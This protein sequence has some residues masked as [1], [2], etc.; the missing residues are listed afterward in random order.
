MTSQNKKLK[1]SPPA[2]PPILTEKAGG[3]GGM[4]HEAA[5]ASAEFLVFSSQLQG[6]KKLSLHKALE[7]IGAAT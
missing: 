1:I 5:P 3:V 4:F 6:S 2:P 7:L